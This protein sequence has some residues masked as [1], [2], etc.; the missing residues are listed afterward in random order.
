MKP[1]YYD[2]DAPFIDLVIFTDW[3]IGAG[4]YEGK[5]VDESFIELLVKH[6]L[7]NDR[8][9]CYVLD[10]LMECTLRNSIGNIFGQYLSPRAQKY[11]IL[12]LLEP[13][14]ESGK[15]LGWVHSNHSQ[16]LTRE[17]DIYLG[18][19][20]AR[21]LNFPFH[22]YQGAGFFKIGRVTYMAGFHHGTG[23]GYTEGAKI[24]A[25]DRIAAG[26]PMS[27][28]YCLGHSHVVRHFTRVRK[29]P[30]II[31]RRRGQQTS[32]EIRDHLQHVCICGSMMTYD[33]SY[34]EAKGYPQAEC[35]AVSIRLHG[36]NNGQATRRIE[37]FRI[38]RSGGKLDISG[39]A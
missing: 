26:L 19:E 18:E 7:K 25:A 17:A 5:I 35:S 29:C 32:C 33:G 12:D 10:D 39:V 31:R 2:F 16:R 8:C 15:I 9:Y 37:F 23:G 14:A 36:L 24:N 22:G 20:I 28:I 30:T 21:Q 34:A 27:D 6:V 11:R 4:G 38:I 1:F 13:L 3:H